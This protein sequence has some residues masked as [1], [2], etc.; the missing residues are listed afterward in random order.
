MKKITEP[1]ELELYSNYIEEFTFDQIDEFRKYL[2]QLEFK[3]KK[4]CFFKDKKQ[5]FIIIKFKN[6][7][8]D[9]FFR[10][11][12]NEK[13]INILLDEIN[14]IAGNIKERNRKKISFKVIIENK[15]PED[16]C[17]IF[18]SINNQTEKNFNTIF[19]KI[20]E[21]LLN[22]FTFL[23]VSIIILLTIQV[24]GKLISWGILVKTISLDNLSILINIYLE[25]A[26]RNLSILLIGVLIYIIVIIF[27]YYKFISKKNYLFVSKEYNNP[28]LNETLPYLKA[29]INFILIIFLTFIYLDNPIFNSKITSSLAKEYIMKTREPSFRKIYIH[30]KNKDIEYKEE[31][32]LLL[33][34]KDGIVYY[35]KEG[36]IRDVLKDI[37]TNICKNTKDEK[38]KIKYTDFLIELLKLSDINKEKG[39]SSKNPFFITL[40]DISFKDEHVDINEVF[41]K[42]NKSKDD[43]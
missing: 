7:I 36:T 29:G 2:N 5:V 10:V 25:Y 19:T 17:K 6:K 11:L 31:N 13:D 28:F 40:K 4:L 21:Y 41:C 33:G 38:G 43:K 42:E 37:P 14:K 16:I 39:I 1:P 26:L 35:L 18:Y 3:E 15:V 23:F 8:I 9:S 22:K 24:S 32:I 27:I 12:K 34:I 20:N 30:K